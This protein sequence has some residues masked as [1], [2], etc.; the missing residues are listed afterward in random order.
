MGTLIMVI[1]GVFIAL[2]GAL[3]T[4]YYAA[5]LSQHAN[6]KA[7]ATGVITQ[8]QQI[9]SAA[10]L[11]YNRTGAA[12]GAVAELIKANYLTNMPSEWKLAAVSGSTTLYAENTTLS[13][14]VC[15]KADQLLD[16]SVTSVPACSSSNAAKTI[17]CQ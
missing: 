6:L 17:C 14:A 8:G 7:Q 11:Y 1:L 13:Q 2:F 4:I 10:V 16:P 12:P 15:L 5:P 9:R 3:A